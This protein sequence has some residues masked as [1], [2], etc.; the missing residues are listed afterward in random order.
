MQNQA[1]TDSTL[2]SAETVNLPHGGQ[3]TAARRQ[4]P[5][6]PEPFIDLS[7]GINPVPYP[8][9]KLD[10]N[11]WCR[12]PE[13]EALVD[14]QRAAATAYRVADPAMVVV[15][16]GTQILIS[17]LPHLLRHSTAT[18]LA[19]TYGE[20]RAAWHNAAAQTHQVTALDDLPPTGAIVL[21]NP[22]NPDGRRLE[23]STLLAL[24]DT[25]VQRGGT[26]IVDEA[27]ADFDPDLS[28]A[29]AL[30]HPALII[31]RSFGKAYG[32]AGLRLGFALTAPA[33]AHRLR[34][35]L[36]PWATSG[37]AA[38]IGTLALQDEPWRLAAAARLNH[39]A[40]RLDALLESAGLT[41]LGGTI[42]F[43]LA[44]SPAASSLFERLGA[45]GILVRRFDTNPAWLRFGLPADHPAWDRLE[46]TLLI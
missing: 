19:P 14:L 40:A 16:P 32:L 39:D 4:F 18:I 28:L 30:P 46:K 36:G 42:L 9:P 27:F 2:P 25:L 20:H 45:A 34:T 35:A 43:R 23:P 1:T 3:L 26:L 10:P 31:L 21:C 6:A 11:L 15:A 17:L 13:P 7:T 5:S 41:I 38:A 33:L 8:L 44:T 24:A 12:L 22:N 37:P 29:S